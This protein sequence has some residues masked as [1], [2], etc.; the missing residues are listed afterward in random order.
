MSAERVLLGGG[1]QPRLDIPIPTDS[2]RDRTIYMP[3]TKD[4]LFLR[5]DTRGPARQYIYDVLPSLLVKNWTPEKATK[6]FYDL[7]DYSWLEFEVHTKLLYLCSL[8]K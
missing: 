3:I 8:K 4:R 2:H 7:P 1:P 6:W 5:K